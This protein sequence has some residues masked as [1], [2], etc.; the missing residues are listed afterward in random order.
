MS[1]NGREN[2]P[3]AQDS[4]LNSWLSLEGIHL[5]LQ[6]ISDKI[7]P[8]K[9]VDSMVRVIQENASDII[10][11]E[12]ATA[13]NLSFFMTALELDM[14]YHISFVQ[15]APQ[16][17]GDFIKKH[18]YGYIIVDLNEEDLDA[19][20]M[21]YESPTQ[22]EARDTETVDNAL[23]PNP[24]SNKP[25]SSGIESLFD[26]LRRK[27]AEA[28][29]EAAGLS[30]GENSTEQSTSFEDPDNLHLSIDISSNPALG[31]LNSTSVNIDSTSF[32]HQSHMA[33]NDSLIPLSPA[34]P[35][36]KLGIATNRPKILMQT[37]YQ[38]TAPLAAGAPNSST[39]SAALNV[40]QSS[41]TFN[42]LK[43]DKVIDFVNNIV[44]NNPD[45][46]SELIDTNQQKV[47]KLYQAIDFIKQVDVYKQSFIDTLKD[48]NSYG[49]G[50]LGYGEE[51]D[52]NRAV[53]NMYND[54]STSPNSTG[55]WFLYHFINGV[56]QSKSGLSKVNGSSNNPRELSNNEEVGSSASNAPG[57]TDLMQIL[58][59]NSSQAENT[60]SAPTDAAN[61][62]FSGT[63]NTIT[64]TEPESQNQN[65]GYNGVNAGEYDQNK[66]YSFTLSENQK[67]I[68]GLETIKSRFAGNSDAMTAH[69]AQLLYA[70][71]FSSYAI[72]NSPLSDAEALLTF[73]TENLLSQEIGDAITQEQIGLLDNSKK[74]A[75]IL[76]F[77]TAGQ[78]I[79]PFANP[80]IY[81]ETSEKR[82]ISGVEKWIDPNIAN[83]FEDRPLK[84][85]GLDEWNEKYSAIHEAAK[86]KI[87]SYTSKGNS[88]I[89][90][91]EVLR[92]LYS[93]SSGNLSAWSPKPWGNAAGGSISFMIPSPSFT[94]WDVE[95][96]NPN[97]G[98]Q[99]VGKQYGSASI[100]AT[101]NPE[102]I[103]ADT[104]RAGVD[105]YNTKKAI[106]AFWLLS[107]ISLFNDEEVFWFFAYQTTQ[108]AV[109]IQQGDGADTLQNRLLSIIS[110]NPGLSKNINPGEA[111]DIIKNALSIVN[112]LL[113]EIEKNIYYDI[114][115][116]ANDAGYASTSPG[117]Y[118][119]SVAA[120][121]ANE[122]YSSP[123]SSNIYKSIEPWQN[124]PDTYTINGNY[125]HLQIRALV[126]TIASEISQKVVSSFPWPI[127]GHYASKD[128]F[129]T[130]KLYIG[131]RYN[132]P[133]ISAEIAKV[134]LPIVENV[135]P[136]KGPTRWACQYGKWQS[137]G[138][139]LDT[140]DFVLNQLV[141]SYAKEIISEGTPDVLVSW[142]ATS[143]E[144]FGS[145]IEKAA[146]RYSFLANTDDFVP[147][148]WIDD[149][150]VPKN[151]FES[152]PLRGVMGSMITYS[153][154]QR[155]DARRIIQFLDSIIDKFKNIK[156]DISLV[157][158][159]P[160]SDVL[161]DI[162][163]LPGIEMAEVVEYSSL[164]QTILREYIASEERPRAYSGYLP[165]N[166][167]LSTGYA[168]I[169]T[170]YID[171]ALIPSVV[172]KHTDNVGVAKPN[173]GKILTIGIPAGY[174]D[175]QVS[176]TNSE[177]YPIVNRLIKIN[178]KTTSVIGNIQFNDIKRYYWP[179]LF[180]NNASVASVEIGSTAF[181]TVEYGY[182][183][184]DTY[185]YKV[186]A[187]S[188]IETM[189]KGIIETVQNDSG[190]G[191][192]DL[193]R[194]IMR[195]HF[196][197]FAVK[198]YLNVYAGL[199]VDEASF[200]VNK[201]SNIL[202]LDELANDNLD[203]IL[204]YTSATN[205]ENFVKDGK[206]IPFH[207]Y[208]AKSSSNNIAAAYETYTN[209][210]SITQS[211]LFSADQMTTKVLSPN[212]FDRV[213]S[214]YTHLGEL[215]IPLTALHEVGTSSLLPLDN[216]NYV[217]DLNESADS[218]S[219][220]NDFNVQI[221]IE[222]TT[223]QPKD[224]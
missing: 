125:H 107:Q 198:T 209:F 151:A 112:C 10:P 37:T 204:D 207:E 92:A 149:A 88:Q 118:T 72:A 178:Q 211:R 48:Y 219:I 51:L 96:E 195:N 106:Y 188:T 123:F 77:N 111:T 177:N 82:L 33:D 84:F 159:I 122:I 50:Y 71:L 187:A 36:S 168:N 15:S 134:F 66:L 130:G 158:E 22:I 203:L 9:V 161:F 108:V 164:R 114:A 102:E 144:T 91:N 60:L 49:L 192:E 25:E 202:Y 63:G 182:I 38:E 110:G 174:I 128:H 56:K 133:F 181:E 138:Y 32:V 23:T 59:F 90:I 153:I 68:D 154:Y 6:N 136:S 170:E 67:L 126:L 41:L 98:D 35:L 121:I 155:E 131:V 100:I 185:K 218:N 16:D 31:M 26:R 3:Q 180:I 20:S 191:S 8:N 152:P 58:D 163:K 27:A 222:C 70:E 173:E 65:L 201:E 78:S 205:A 162:A 2:A 160:N 213:F 42:I 76:K 47:L 184:K 14:S 62:L 183:D 45:L 186:A 95:F 115:V 7:D 94:G 117:A 142:L 220:N 197:D 217:F 109:P 169:I 156:T 124:N 57:L 93:W 171:N 1:N 75:Q 39:N 166:S 18:G 11:G 44:L 146:N 28:A 200:S 119:D 54:L 143:G 193:A 175:S 172:G 86:S 55:G 196:D 4:S 104:T 132:T 150:E 97:P 53:R 29:E 87:S 46:Y 80:G 81:S 137:A 139:K 101:S 105:S 19:Y 113:S 34:A 145:F 13:E 40:I 83:I 165:S 215:S 116:L 103:A 199:N 157:G 120:G 206:I 223:L 21:G 69:V 140:S 129:G 85:E 148:T 52:L 176:E 194:Q 141:P 147:Y 210:I 64:G 208:L 12:T 179:A 79:M 5:Q 89:V 99:P 216:D 43:Q 212:V 190:L 224:S 221:Y 167:T 61:N 73:N 30:A 17:A 214:F 127:D 24:E 135:D 189:L 74:L